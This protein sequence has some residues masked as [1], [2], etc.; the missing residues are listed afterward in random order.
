M[1]FFGGKG[2]VIGREIKHPAS[3]ASHINNQGLVDL[4]IDIVAIDDQGKEFSIPKNQIS[5]HQKSQING[6]DFISNVSA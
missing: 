3:S 5:I 2:R 6:I 4:S 1:D